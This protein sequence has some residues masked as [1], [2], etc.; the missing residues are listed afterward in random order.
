MFTE[1]ALKH[2]ATYIILF[3]TSNHTKLHIKK[4]KFWEHAYDPSIMS[5]DGL[6]ITM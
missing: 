3:Y 2:T 5:A 4:I 6:I 1:H